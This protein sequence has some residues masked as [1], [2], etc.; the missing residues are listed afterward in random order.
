MSPNI[1]GLGGH[2]NNSQQ[3]QYRYTY[4]QILP[5]KYTFMLRI[6]SLYLHTFSVNANNATPTPCNEVINTASID[7]FYL[8]DLVQ[9]TI[10]KPNDALRITNTMVTLSQ[11]IETITNNTKTI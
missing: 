5:Q 3:Q 1:A 4:N 7:T 6:L 11:F 9:H 10:L 2:N 8:H